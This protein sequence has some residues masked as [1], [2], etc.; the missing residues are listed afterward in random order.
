MCR[1]NK[2]DR[3]VIHEAAGVYWILG[4]VFSSK[5]FTRV[6]VPIPHDSP[7]GSELQVRGPRQ[8][9]AVP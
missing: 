6:N 8:S 9:V 5:R 1:S 4:C 2:N 3:E 7:A